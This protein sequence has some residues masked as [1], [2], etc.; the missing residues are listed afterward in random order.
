MFFI[1]ITGGRAGAGGVWVW[2]WVN[3]G[4]GS[5]VTNG[6]NSMGVIGQSVSGGGGIVS[7]IIYAGTGGSLSFQTS[8]G[9]NGSSA[10]SYSAASPSPTIS[11]ASA[12]TIMTFGANG[13]GIM[14]QSVNG[15][16]GI[17][18]TYFSGG[19]ITLSPS[20]IG[21]QSS[22][23]DGLAVSVTQTGSIS[24]SGPAAMGIVAQSIGGGGGY[25]S[26]ASQSGA[27]VING[28]NIVIG[29]SS[30]SSG[31]GGNVVITVNAP[32]TT[33]GKGSVGIVAQSVGGGGG[34]LATSGISGLTPV[35]TGGT[36]NGGAVSVTINAPIIASGAG[37]YGVVAQSVG[38]GGGMMINENGV[39]DYSANAGGN[40]G[41]VAV[42]DNSSITAIGG[43]ALGIYAKSLGGL[44]DPSITIAHGASVIASGGGSAI[45]VDGLINSITN[46][47]YIG[48][49]NPVSDTAIQIIGAGGTTSIVNNGVLSGAINNQGSS[50][51]FTNSQGAVLYLPGALNLG[52]G[53]FTNAGF[54]QFNPQG[55]S[56]VGATTQS[57]SFTQTGTGTL[58]V[59]VNLNAGQ[60]DLLEV[61]PGNTFNLA[62]NIKPVLLNAGLIAPGIKGPITILENS[63]G[64]LV[65]NQLGVFSTAIVSFDVAKQSNGIQL[66]ATAN[67]APA[68]LSNYG[69]QLGGAIGSYQAAG[70]SALF[71]AATAQLVTIPT[72]GGLDQAYNKLAGS[73]IAAVPQVTY[74]AVSRGMGTVSDRLN[75]WRVGDSF[76]TQTK[77][78]QGLMY[79]VGV[80]GLAN[81]PPVPQMA[82]GN[83]SFN[84]ASLVADGSLPSAQY[85]AGD[86]R[87][88][89][90]PFQDNISTNSLSDTVYGGSFGVE[91]ESVDRK[92]I[93]GIGFT[94]SQSSYTYSSANMPSTP[95]SDTNYGAAFY[96]GAREESAYLSAIAYLGG[97]NSGF[98]RQLQGLG[99]DSTTNVTLHSNV[100]AARIEAGYNLMPHPEGQYQLQLTPFAAI[101]PTQIRQN[102]A[103]EY[104]NGLGSGFYYGSNIN[105][106]VPVYVGAEFSGQVDLGDNQIVRPFLRVSWVGDLMSQS[107]MNA[108]YS[109]GYGVSLY[110]NG[111]PSFGN[112]VLFKGGAKYNWGTNV[113]AYAT[114]N[115]EQGNA[116]YNYRGI[117]GSIGAMYAW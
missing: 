41:A 105:T 80:M 30:S 56:L 84:P 92:Y 89:I 24:T 64:S 4:G 19:S 111:S 95:G 18:S 40:G 117:G 52:G 14:A 73:A 25:I 60:A 96:A 44:S 112:A 98:S 99:F 47:G 46:N 32:I 11:I 54:L 42:V 106:A 5:I 23:G 67:F 77:G 59:K 10:T 116:S 93:G 97:S 12:A 100:M 86:Y 28:S 6:V 37:A 61:T 3:L 88:W 51:N 94:I 22:N 16:G 62:G 8:L 43:G 9:A 45:V 34:I 87:A 49:A 48:V 90:T 113:S 57:G 109:P 72:V 58:G 21:G 69:G 50:L 38:G 39:T 33:S 36:G 53:T 114:I 82:A 108:A 63:G 107:T 27:S 85:R 102:G 15:G 55:S 101:Q 31:N 79:G 103:N 110:S 7:N 20:Y 66:S 71:Q 26:L 68:G 65:D 83:V 74:Q 81:A 35:T 91:S 115:V 17:S 13:I 78:I 104:F 2:V 1:I 70:S 76:I 75:S 29:G